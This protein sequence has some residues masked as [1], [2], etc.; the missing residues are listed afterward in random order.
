MKLWE[1]IAIRGNR[2]VFYYDTKHTFEAED[3]A[4]RL[5]DMI[6]TELELK[7]ASGVLFLCIGTDR[8]TGDSLGPLIGYKLKETGLEH[9]EVMGT[10]DRPVHAMNLETY[11][12]ILRLRYPNYVVVAVDASVG[13]MEHI[14][15]VTLGR[16]ALKPGLGVSKELRAVGDLFIT[17]IVG[18][19]GNYDPLMLQ[20][21]RLS[22]VMRMADCISRSI[23]LV[24]KLWENSSTL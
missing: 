17:G 23:Y 2:D 6:S 14:G 19:C 5:Y 9:I 16:G 7:K 11:Q 3:F 8:S 15:Y 20:S 12:T 18:S 10:L 22:I 4:S 1:R 13:N 21:I 24:E